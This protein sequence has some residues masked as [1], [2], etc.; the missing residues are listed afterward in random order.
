MRCL[1]SIN[2]FCKVI[3]CHSKSPQV[4]LNDMQWNRILVCLQDDGARDTFFMPYF[5]PSACPFLYAA[6]CFKEKPYIS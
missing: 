6:Y 1:Y 2:Y 3:K 5:M 4:V